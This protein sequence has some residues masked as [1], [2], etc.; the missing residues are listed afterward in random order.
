MFCSKS[1]FVS[2]R[3]NREL[4]IINQTV[5]TYAHLPKIRHPDGGRRH[6]DDADLWFA[7]KIN[8]TL[9][10]TSASDIYWD[11]KLLPQDK[12]VNFIKG[13]RNHSWNTTKYCYSHSIGITNSPYHNLHLFLKYS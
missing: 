5:D 4:K 9:K 2:L 8:A 7:S 3:L 11:R 13:V 6:V 10:S 12:Q 1:Y